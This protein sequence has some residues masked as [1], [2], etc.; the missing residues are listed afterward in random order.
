MVKT[1][2]DYGFEDPIKKKKA[3]A[4]AIRKKTY[5]PDRKDLENE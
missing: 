3:S 2:K 5:H 1:L 4:E